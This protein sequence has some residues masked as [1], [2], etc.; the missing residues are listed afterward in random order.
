MN[1]DTANTP[2]LVAY[3]LTQLE[4]T[5]ATGLLAVNEKLDNLAHNF[6]TKA[7]L[8]HERQIAAAEHKD[9]RDD[10]S[11][12]KGEVHEIKKWKDGIIGK[13]AGAAVFVVIA[14]VLA[15]YGLDRF[16]P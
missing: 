3:R 7:E 8:E 12:V 10:L 15:I 14:M 9:I 5:T 4:K 13:I 11:T 1:D 16:L 2:E 6:A